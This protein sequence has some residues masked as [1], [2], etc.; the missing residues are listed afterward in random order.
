MANWN[1][2]NTEYDY[3]DDPDRKTKFS[4]TWS[5]TSDSLTVTDGNTKSVYGL[6]ATN[7]LTE[8]LIKWCMEFGTPENVAKIKALLKDS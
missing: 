4:A 7:L 5:T 6:E 2:A 1:F 3:Y 8:A